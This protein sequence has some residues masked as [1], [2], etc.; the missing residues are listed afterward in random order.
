M[1]NES[2]PAKPWQSPVLESPE[3][4]R[5]REEREG[6]TRFFIECIKTA[7]REV[8]EERKDEEQDFFSALFGGK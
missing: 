1:A 7:M 2:K 8:A 3:E 4:R 6:Q 5:K